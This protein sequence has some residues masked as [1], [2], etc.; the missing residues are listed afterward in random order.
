MSEI[1]DMSYAGGG[2][3]CAQLIETLFI[4]AFDNPQLAQ[5]DD[6][7]NLENMPGRPVFTTD[8]HV[9]SPLFFPGGDIGKLAVC[10]TVN[11]I[12]VSGAT[13]RYLSAGFIIEEGF[14]LNDLKRIVASMAETAREAGVAIV[15]GDTKIVERGK[16]DGIFITTAGIGFSER[17]RMGTDTIAVD[18]V[19]IING[20]LADHGMTILC[21]RDNLNV[22]GPLQSDVAALHTLTHAMLETAPRIR[23]MRDITRGGL[24]TICNEIANDARLRMSIV[25]SKIPVHATVL[26]ACDLYGIDP[27]TVANEGKLLAFCPASEAEKLLTTMRQ[28]PLGKQATAIGRVIA[29]DASA[30]VIATTPYGGQRLIPWTSGTPLPR[31]C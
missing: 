29:K 31:I 6:Y 30:Q 16:G 18:D 12:C 17:P 1:I 22:E 10:G 20:S 27:L 25:E 9:V 13:P 14:A 4:A 23:M 7:A 28:H 15:C 21:Q 11:D 26:A 8:C 24:A 5:K 2:Y 19:L 3:K